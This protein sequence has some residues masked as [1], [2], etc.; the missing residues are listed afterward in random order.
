MYFHALSGIVLHIQFV[1]A[2]GDIFWVWI[3]AGGKGFDSK[4][5]NNFTPSTW[6]L[7][8]GRTWPRR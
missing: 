8:C 7:P 2:N 3:G 4:E 5:I 1:A 6:I